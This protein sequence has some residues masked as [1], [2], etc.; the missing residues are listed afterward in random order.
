MVGKGGVTRRDELR[1]HLA[2]LA[3]SALVAGSFSMGGRI[4]ND[5]D[6]V[7]LTAA[8]FVLA[9]GLL[10]G[11]A[12]AIGRLPRSTFEAPWRYLITG[13][14]FGVY[15]ILMFEGLKTAKP[16]STAAVF[17]LTPLITAFFGW[18]IMSQV[19]TRRMALAL[20]LGGAGALWV[21]FRGELD[22]LVRLEVGRGE[23]IYF[24]GC[25]A[26]AVYIP[27]VQKLGRGEGVFAFTFATLGVGAVLLGIVGASRIVATDW[28]ALPL[29]VWGVLLYLSVFASFASISLLQFGAMRLKAAKVMAYTYMTPIFVILWEVALAGDLPTAR[30]LPGIG[31]T[32]AALLIL[33]REGRVVAVPQAERR[34]AV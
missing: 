15:F 12:L 18:W 31:L 16:V 7:A 27:I 21:I 22:A 29:R 26:H 25:I 9:S 28:G 30:I 4:A 11:A 1:G 24:S 5:I 6:P 34:G 23:A 3:F 20:A 8:R 33:L 19:T 10:G 14:L 13:G 2:M 17:T 32:V